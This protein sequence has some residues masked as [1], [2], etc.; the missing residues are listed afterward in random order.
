MV[1]AST[2]WIAAW[3]RLDRGSFAGFLTDLARVREIATRENEHA[4]ADGLA[5][6][7]MA[8]ELRCGLYASSITS[9]A[10]DLPLEAVVALVQKQIW[11][12][13]QA[14]AY[15]TRIVEPDQRLRTLLELT[16]LSD[17]AYRPLA[18]E[19]TVSEARELFDLPEGR[20]VVTAVVDGFGRR[21]RSARRTE[22]VF[23]A[24]CH[25]AKRL[26]SPHD[27]WLLEQI[28]RTLT[29]LRRTPECFVAA[30][31]AVEPFLDT[32]TA[33]KHRNGAD[34]ATRD[35]AQNLI[36]DP[37]GSVVERFEL[38]RKAM[39]D[40]NDDQPFIIGALRAAVNALVAAA[41]AMPGEQHAA[42]E[43][44]SRCVHQLPASDVAAALRAIAPLLMPAQMLEVLDDA[45]RIGR[46]EDR[47]YVLDALLPA[48]EREPPEYL[49]SDLTSVVAKTTRPSVRLIQVLSRLASRL[50]K[51]QLH[52]WLDALTNSGW[53]LMDVIDLL[54]TLARAYSRPSF[55]RDLAARALALIVLPLPEEQTRDVLAGLRDWLVPA[56]ANN[57]FEPSDLGRD[58]RSLRRRLLCL[59][60][61]CAPPRDDVLAAVWRLAPGAPVGASLIS[62]LSAIP[63]VSPPS[64]ILSDPHRA[65][66]EA[67]S[68][69]GTDQITA[70]V[71][72][73]RSIR[74]FEAL[75]E[76]LQ[77]LAGLAGHVPEESLGQAAA[78]VLDLADPWR[79]PA[80]ALIR[81]LTIASVPPLFPPTPDALRAVRALV[82]VACAQDLG[83]FFESWRD[84]PLRDLVREQ[85]LVVCLTEL[86]KRRHDTAATALMGHAALITRPS[87]ELLVALL[88]C[89][90]EH[91]QSAPFDFARIAPNVGP[92]VMTLWLMAAPSSG[93][94]HRRRGLLSELADARQVDGETHW[95]QMVDAVGRLSSHRDRALWLVDFAEFLPTAVASDA[96]AV[97]RNLES[98]AARLVA[99]SALLT[100]L[101]G[102]D[103]RAV[104][105]EALTLARRVPQASAIGS[106]LVEIAI[107]VGASDTALMSEAM[108]TAVSL[109]DRTARARTFAELAGVLLP[110]QLVSASQAF[111]T[112][113]DVA[114]RA[115]TMLAFAAG[116]RDPEQREPAIGLIHASLRELPPSSSRQAGM[117][118]LSPML[119][120]TRRGPVL[121]EALR[122]AAGPG[123]FERTDLL[124]A[125][126]TAIP[127]APAAVIHQALSW[128]ARDVPDLPRA[129]VI[130]ALAPFLP[131]WLLLPAISLLAESCTDRQIDK[132][133]PYISPM[134]FERARK[135][136]PYLSSGARQV[137]R[138]IAQIQESERVSFI[139]PRAGVAESDEDLAEQ[140][141]VATSD[142]E[143]AATIQSV[144]LARDRAADARELLVRAAAQL[145]DPALRLSTTPYLSAL[146]GTRSLPL[147]RQAV[148]RIECAAD[149]SL[150]T[151]HLALRH[152]D[153]DRQRLLQSALSSAAAEPDP[154][155]RSMAAAEL[156]VMVPE[157]LNSA[158]EVIWSGA[159]PTVSARA[160]R[161][162]IPRLSDESAAVAVH[163]LVHLD[164]EE[165]R[166]LALSAV[167]THLGFVAAR[168]ALTV[169]AGFRGAVVRSRALVA[170]APGLADADQG[171]ALSL[172]ESIR[173][174]FAWLQ[175]LAALTAR[176]PAALSPELAR[177]AT[178]VLEACN[179]DEF[180]ASWLEQVGPFWPVRALP[181]LVQCV[182]AI[183]SNS[184]RGELLA[185]LIAARSD[186]RSPSVLQAARG[187]DDDFHRAVVL[188]RIAST[189]LPVDEA[190]LGE[191]LAAVGRAGT[192]RRYVDAL[193]LM[194][195]DTV[196]TAVLDCLL[197][198]FRIHPSFV[199][200][201]LRTVVA[202][203]T[204]Q[205]AWSMVE[206]LCQWHQGLSSTERVDLLC[207]L[208][209]RV[210]PADRP[211]LLDRIPLL[212]TERATGDL[213][214]ELLP[215]LEDEST[216]SAALRIAESITSETVR[217]QTLTA[218]L[219]CLGPDQQRR[220]IRSIAATNK[221]IE[222]LQHLWWALP[223]ASETVRA[224]IAD[225][226]RRF[227][228]PDYAA[229]LLHAL[230]SS[231]RDLSPL[232]Q[233]SQIDTTAE[234][235]L[236]ELLEECLS[237]DTPDG[238]IAAEPPKRLRRL[239]QVLT[240]LHRDIPT[241]VE[242]AAEIRRA[243][244]SLSPGEVADLL[245]QMPRYIGESH[246]A[247]VIADLRPPMTLTVQKAAVESI[248]R[249]ENP[250]SQHRAWAALSPHLSREMFPQ[251]QSIWS[252]LLEIGAHEPRA[253]FLERLQGF[254]PVLQARGGDAALL[255]G[256][257]AIH[258]AGTV[259][260]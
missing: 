111:R 143:R 197:R 235:V 229:A 236:Q 114:A 83:Q 1:F 73:L 90:V 110:E 154:M 128:L 65:L 53:A 63:D 106:H 140:L 11:S 85:L 207:A 196:P 244:H 19:T 178:S 135:L 45:R 166:A 220:V 175:A 227:E 194:P 169:I 142:R 14:I 187:L 242:R 144:A 6:T 232:G 74:P 127:E 40:S 77:L 139:D 231:A 115:R 214:C 157:L 193:A 102:A 130:A 195:V 7:F 145:G 116:I 71:E 27:R 151:A 176:W 64:E 119:P 225:E 57:S 20:A 222:R 94:R 192:R 49:A 233:R 92:G 35:L 141:R 109:S 133:A 165:D 173:T 47:L 158:L 26:P 253:R 29:R 89:A 76:A 239:A 147:A 23:T 199:E 221:E 138:R 72:A 180:A 152:G 245:I 87:E 122:N 96:L 101:E 248:C 223:D 213:L 240:R 21:P 50:T 25:L 15:G 13:A 37:S 255:Q 68:Q 12:P 200:A 113:D 215:L 228:N 159:E 28:E 60:E 78:Q 80:D 160:I 108:A 32:E 148:S 42:M 118:V 243:L 107:D 136:G 247:A 137:L 256:I 216:V 206:V 171:V 241:E 75:D 54:V 254:V 131:I 174:D 81:A 43:L 10:A 56:G 204:P 163:T 179:E 103:R 97:A 82:R 2:A 149:R 189:A 164:A 79:T 34:E 8:D 201:A 61:L 36:I 9:I 125:L 59:L 183:K 41:R 52:G 153:K 208:A 132:V 209:W 184:L 91:H 93:G 124:A 181:E 104:L 251:L 46:C 146:S 44:A 188:G 123:G 191:A 161:D 30:V 252:E 238:V 67:W 39:E 249:I 24:A 5:S 234:T 51:D 259:W 182:G 31:R 150:I 70:L 126:R 129:E 58:P 185:S 186:L 117:L 217:V 55:R 168:A 198:E 190:L 4:A 69:E 210:L 18:L 17:D 155:A 211:N 172:L 98:D 120:G 48:V 218:L 3:E 84:A 62:G 202:H 203:V 246:Q 105:T 177:S 95:R 22:R 258:D 257:Q 230:E 167:A 156:A 112:I 38:L 16:A 66:V 250:S 100:I 212:C 99:L 121:S 88:R 237:H 224:A 134:V 260:P 226:A 205:Q 33:A 162:L 219:G 170:V 86:A